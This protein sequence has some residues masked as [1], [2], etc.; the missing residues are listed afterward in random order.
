MKGELF[1]FVVDDIISYFVNLGIEKIEQFRDR[2]KLEKFSVEIKDEIIDSIN[3]KY[4]TEPYFDALSSFYESNKINDKILNRIFNV[5]NEESVENMIESLSKGFVKQ[6][7]KYSVYETTVKEILN[8]IYK[9]IFNGLNASGVLSDNE[10]TQLLVVKYGRKSLQEIS[11]V[12]ALTR[13]LEGQVE[14]IKTMIAE[15]PLSMP[16][17]FK[18]LS[19]T[20]ETLLDVSGYTE[21]IQKIE[22]EIQKKHDFQEA[23]EEY[24]K[25]IPDLYETQGMKESLF[26]DIYIN[27]ALCYANLEK[28]SDAKTYIQRAARHIKDNN[29]SKIY[30]VNGYIQWKENGR[31]GGEAVHAEMM[32]ALSI[33][34]KYISA[35]LLLC[36][37]EALLGKETA[38]IISKLDELRQEAP[39]E[40]IGEVL[41][42]YG[43]VYRLNGQFAKAKEYFVQAENV[44]SDISNLANLG[45]VY[46]CWATQDNTSDK[47]HLK[48]NVDYPKMFKAVHYLKQ[49]IDDTSKEA[50]SYKA[51]IIEVYISACMICDEY[52]LID[53]IGTI[54]VG[55]LDYEA[56]RTLIFHR[57]RKGDKSALELLQKEDKE[58]YEV[59]GIVGEREEDSL[60]VIMDKINIVS[61]DELFRY[62]NLGMRVALNIRNIEKYQLLR[63][64][65][66]INNIECPYLD[67]YDAEYNA[68]I[69]QE[70]KSKNYFDRIIYE[71]DDEYILIPA[72]KFYKERNYFSELEV[73]YEQTL[74]KIFD[75]K[76]VCH[77]IKGWIGE[78][79]GFLIEHNIDKALELFNVLDGKIVDDEVYNGIKNNLFYRI[80]DVKKV[81]EAN[82]A[83]QK[84]NPDIKLQIE[85]LILLKYDMRFVEAHDKGLKLLNNKELS[86]Q[87]KIMLLE[88]LSEC[89]LFMEDFDKSIE[90]ISKAKDL[91]KELVY[92]P[93]HQLYMSRLLRCGDHD[94]LKYGVEFQKTHPNI[95]EWLKP[96]TITTTNEQD[97]ESLSDEFAE[98]VREQSAKFQEKIDFYKKNTISFYQ[99]QHVMK[100]DM[101]SALSYPECYGIKIV[102]G[103]GNNENIQKQTEE[104]GSVIAIDAFT[105]L[106]LETYNLSEILNIFETIYI[107]YST[108]EEIEKLYLQN[109][110]KVIVNVY[111][112]IKSDLRFEKCPN[113]A[114]Y[115][116][117][118][119]LFHPQSFLDTL[120]IAK[121]KNCKFLCFDA[122]AKL[123]FAESKEY[124]LGI[125]PVIQ[126]IKNSQTDDLGAR[127]IYNIIDKKLTFV[128]FNANDIIYALKQTDD[129]MDNKLKGFLK[130]N[131]HCDMDSFCRVYLHTIRLLLRSKDENLP[132]FLEKLLS[133]TDRVY[134]W[135]KM[136][137]WRYSQ[138]QNED[139]LSNYYV[140]AHFVIVMLSGLIT[141]FGKQEKITC[142]LYCREY[143]FI[144]KHFINMISEACHENLILKEDVIS[145]L[146]QT[147]A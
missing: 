141:L 86:K 38:S 1:M 114:N 56:A 115:T 48:L 105:L 32:K 127:M 59:V 77:N 33:N 68:I 99:F 29:N 53:E 18:V 143:K 135:A 119:G 110:C 78:V 101:L 94:G 69:G 41:Q 7:A 10:I 146:A 72:V 139:S 121:R 52:N 75:R 111:H 6:Y 93:V 5:D 3:K 128:N 30:Y 133:L 35:A 31:N 15:K 122:R 82:R 126:K 109:D 104:I 95:T 27:I 87:Q 130:I 97:E 102:I 89:A 138:Y 44:K 125:I 34:P 71:I 42:V 54:D 83:L 61:K 79:F 74:K 118:E 91:G 73:L 57:I 96:V 92:D 116:D 21:K 62:Y 124:I 46:Y 24:Q 20:D 23:I 14:A 4:E 51:D 140:Y 60:D 108:I 55:T 80:L 16:C 136:E 113:F 22:N 85:E 107:T 90:Y 106:F 37:S 17:G 103:T 40:R 50:I 137:K 9:I 131:Q 120:E 84:S 39:E 47:R 36:I 64:E 129:Q 142:Q 43:L 144:P 25:L 2:K 81:L 19:E 13:N 70:E 147:I 63:S 65:V 8:D 49:V 67:L 58:F 76:I 88:L 11:E 12:K 134:N 45:I 117:E 98:F 132:M 145:E 112:L 26:A 66:K 28:Y 123:F 100:M